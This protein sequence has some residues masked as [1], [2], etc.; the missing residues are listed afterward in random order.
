MNTFNNQLYKIIDPEQTCQICGNPYNNHNL[1]HQF[2]PRQNPDFRI[3]QNIPKS[4]EI[5]KAY[6]LIN[7]PETYL[8]INRNC[9][10]CLAC[11][12]PESE[13]KSTTHKFQ[14]NYQ[15]PQCFTFVHQQNI[16]DKNNKK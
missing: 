4:I 13:H 8:K 9:Y 7:P 14:P 15:S 6:Q 2:Q 12:R 1:L 3:R 11:E 5:E 16:I 10:P